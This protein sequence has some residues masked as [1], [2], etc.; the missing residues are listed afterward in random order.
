MEMERDA[1]SGEVWGDLGADSASSPRPPSAPKAQ[2]GRET[3]AKMTLSSSLSDLLSDKDQNEATANVPPEKAARMIAAGQQRRAAQDEPSSF[4]EPTA[5]GQPP[6]PMVLPRVAAPSVRA[7]MAPP[8][9]GAPAKLPPAMATA[10]GPSAKLPAPA[11]APAVSVVAAAAPPPREST[12]SRS[13]ARDRPPTRGSAMVSMPDE[14][15]APAARNRPL[16]EQSGLHEVERAAKP[17][18][19][20]GAASDIFDDDD[21]ESV[22]GL[23][24]T[25]SVQS[26]QRRTNLGEPSQFVQSIE[27][28]SVHESGDETAPPSQI[29]ES[30][31]PSESTPR[32]IAASE[33][34]PSESMSSSPDTS[35]VGSDSRSVEMVDSAL[36]IRP[37]AKAM[38]LAVAA[39][40]ARGSRPRTMASMEQSSSASDPKRPQGRA[41]QKDDPDATFARSLEES[42]S[43]SEKDELPASEPSNEDSE[44]TVNFDADQLRKR[45]LGQK[46]NVVAGGRAGVAAIPSGFSQVVAP[47]DAP[48]VK[49]TDENR[50]KARNLFESAVKEAE[51]GRLAPAR[52]NAKLASIYDPDTPEYK[53][54][55]DAWERPA[56]QAKP[57]QPTAQQSQNN[58]K[59]S[60]ESQAEIKALYDEAQRYEDTGDV[61]EALDIL[62]QGV[63]RYPQAAAFHNRIGVILALRKRDYEAAVQAIQRAIDIDPDN[64]HYKSNLGKIVAKMRGRGQPEA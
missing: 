50:R 14:V 42:L 24:P 23:A 59:P 4:E 31:L 22:D 58:S 7:K 1:A 10:K 47:P 6:P 43:L 49:V 39:Q 63:S 5:A 64:L 30:E 13:A 37:A 28:N 34:D 38:P 32:A 11:K 52:M 35:D 62:E 27:V 33:S 55:L 16:D 57:A 9:A 3:S 26:P 15:A 20:G 36:L 25:G 44:D 61:D 45:G 48:R 8:A 17:R 19:N 53:R 54:Q 2:N 29:P 21:D 40:K 46:E 41:A 60:D 12:N 18:G 56:T 51:A